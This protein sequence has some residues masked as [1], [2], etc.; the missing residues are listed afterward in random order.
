MTTAAVT[1]PIPVISSRLGV[2]L[3]NES[4]QLLAVSLEVDAEVSDSLGVTDSVSSGSCNTKS[5]VA[6]TPGSNCGDLGACE[7]PACVDTQVVGAQQRGQRIDRPQPVSVHLLAGDREHL[8]RG[9]HLASAAVPQA[10]D[11]HDHRRPGRG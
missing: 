1:A 3:G 9:L 2:M 10:V 7:R 5:L 4:R 6:S 11:V 8:Q